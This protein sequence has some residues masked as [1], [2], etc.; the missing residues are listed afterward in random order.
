MNSTVGSL[1]A[2]DLYMNRWAMAGVVLGGVVSLALCLTNSIAGVMVGGLSVMVGVIALGC[3]LAMGIWNERK[4]G[5]L[6]FTLSLPVS[7]RGY[8]TARM[9]G[10]LLSFLIP[11]SLLTAATVLMIE[12]S[13]LIPR[14]TI[15]FTVVIFGFLLLDFCLLTAA[16]LLARSEALVTAAL[17]VT[18]TWV[19]LFWWGT[20]SLPAVS[21]AMKSSAVIW[22]GAVLSILAAE[23]VFGACALVLPLHLNARKSLL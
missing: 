18:N 15:P 4:E 6:L 22:D 11:W 10:A 19:T 14:G 3:M 13:S 17:M 2:K 16:A 7:A 20:A 12:L 21:R 1:I 9:L 5:A 23:T 8:L